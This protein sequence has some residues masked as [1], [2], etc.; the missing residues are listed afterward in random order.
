MQDGEIVWQVAGGTSAGLWAVEGHQPDGRVR[1]MLADV[2]GGVA[3]PWPRRVGT[4]LVLGGCVAVVG[5]YA[6]HTCF[7]DGPWSAEVLRFQP[8]GSVAPV[9]DA[10][11]WPA[12]VGVVGRLRAAAMDLRCSRWYAWAAADDQAEGM[13]LVRSQLADLP[14]LRVTAYQA[15]DAVEAARDCALRWGLAG[16]LAMA[17]TATREIERE[18]QEYGGKGPCP[19]TLAVGAA[20][21]GWEMSPWRA[22]KPESWRRVAE[23]IANV[24]LHV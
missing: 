23:G 3:W 17:E 11:G 21:R 6:P 24:P 13:R 19:L 1:R 7:A 5:F 9:V 8:V 10:E 22:R 12:D 16:R 14:G 2:R 20:L 15:G 18:E 4:E